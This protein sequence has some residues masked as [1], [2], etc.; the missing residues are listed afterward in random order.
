MRW[1]A[2]GGLL[3]AAV[4]GAVWLQRSRSAPDLERAPTVEVSVLPDRLRFRLRDPSGDALPVG[5]TWRVWLSTP[6]GALRAVGRA[7]APLEVSYRRAGQ[8]PYRV[9]VGRYTIDARLHRQPGPPVS[10][11]EANVGARAVR[12]GAGREP[13]VVVH[14]LDASGNVA[15]EAV[16]FRIDRPDG[17]SSE[18]SLPVRHLLAW[19]FLP[20]GSRTGLL[21][22]S[23]SSGAARGERGEVDVQPG[24]VS[25]AALRATS[26]PRVSERERLTLE[27]VNARDRFGNPAL[28]GTAVEFSA[29]GSWNLFATRSLVRE[30]AELRLGVPTTE[31]F[32][33]SA[34]SDDWRGGL[35]RLRAETT[36]APS[37]L[38]ARLLRRAERLTLELGVLTD[39]LGALL[40]DGTPVNLELLGND[41][42]EFRM[43]RPL[44]AGRLRWEL[45]PLPSAVH[46]VRVSVQ[47]LSQTLT[48]PR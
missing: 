30:R 31:A 38:S 23:V 14:P 46:S 29:F 32:T 28:N 33:P 39:Q 18:S 6:A 45:P 47:G 15:D 22:V 37:Q 41:G 7:N 26:D 34:S 35:V 1:I 36:L 21:R 4:L 3:I 13:A 27:I 40:D 11:L 8:I 17:T 42:V 16:R 5:L 44:R 24:F 9:Q 2:G 48:L 43:V 20:S 10:P 19:R 12:V 25:R